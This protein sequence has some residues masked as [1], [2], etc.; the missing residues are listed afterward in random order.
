M[1]AINAFL[2]TVEKEVKVCREYADKG[3]FDTAISRKSSF[4]QGQEHISQGIKTAK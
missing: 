2:L 4:Q 3:V 1:N